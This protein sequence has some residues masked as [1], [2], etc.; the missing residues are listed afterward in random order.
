MRFWRL[1]MAATSKITARFR[2]GVIGTVMDGTFTF[3]ECDTLS[4]TDRGGFG[5][6][7]VK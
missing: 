3:E 4:D 7:G 1:F 6:T 2:P 5:S